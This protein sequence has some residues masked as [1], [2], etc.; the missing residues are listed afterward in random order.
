LGHTRIELWS[1]TRFERAHRFYTK[2]G[3]EHDGTI[4]HMTDAFAPYDE[5]FFYKEL[6]S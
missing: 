5:L 6:T 2:H 4:R 1:D 3:F